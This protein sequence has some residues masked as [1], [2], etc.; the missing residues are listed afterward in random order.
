MKRKVCMVF[1][2]VVMA[3]SCSMA[4]V[5]WPSTFASDVAAN[6]AA[7]SASATSGTA[8]CA[9]SFDSLV[10]GWTVLDIVLS[11]VNPFDSRSRTWDESVGIIL[12]G[13]KPRGAVVSFR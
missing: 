12:N 13:T 1:A 3:V 6:E 11:S 10:G 5:N 2:A 7:H 4:D 8:A 9:T